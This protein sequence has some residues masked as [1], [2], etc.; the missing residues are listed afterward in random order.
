MSLESREA[1][2]KAQMLAASLGIHLPLGLGRLLARMPAL[3]GA[4][5]AA[6]NA[7]I[8]LAVGAAVVAI[9]PK[10]DEWMDKLRGI[11]S[12]TADVF[13][14]VADLNRFL[15]SGGKPEALSWLRTEIRNV[16]GD[17]QRVEAHLKRLTTLPGG[18]EMAALAP[19]LSLGMELGQKW[20][21]RKEVALLNEQLANLKKRYDDLGAA[22][23]I[24]VVKEH[25][26]ATED[27]A[28]AM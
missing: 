17:I 16:E 4:M 19:G 12:V 26:K 21:N 25:N 13:T 10:L 27:A 23:P 11:E 14:K 20:T 5:A 15:A 22:I 2:E 7:T 6:F 24:A 9:L 28:K 18:K 3:Q 1:N 8:I